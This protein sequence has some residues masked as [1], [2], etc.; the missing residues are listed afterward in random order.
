MANKGIAMNKIV[1]TR[2]LNAQEKRIL[3]RTISNFPYLGQAESEL[4]TSYAEQ[5]ARYAVAKRA[6]EREPTVTAPIFSRNNGEKIGERPVRN[7]QFANLREALTQV[8]LLEK[9]LTSLNDKRRAAAEREERRKAKIKPVPSWA[10]EQARARAAYELMERVEDEIRSGRFEPT[11]EKIAELGEE[12]NRVA[13]K[14]YDDSE[15]RTLTLSWV[16][17][18]YEAARPPGLSKCAGETHV[19]KELIAAGFY[20][21]LLA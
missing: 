8:R 15:L 21:D 12:L 11:E 1:A 9:R 14:P 18:R 6:T 16:E 2:K 10:S 20:D 4:L 3:G 19:E 7:P 13:R 17:S 5:S